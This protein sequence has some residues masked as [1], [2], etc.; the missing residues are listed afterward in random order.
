MM[1]KIYFYANSNSNRF[2]SE[3]IRGIQV[4][5]IIKKYMECECSTNL[6]SIHNSIIIFIKNNRKLNIETLKNSKNNNNIN[7]ID[8]IDYTEEKN[9]DIID[10]NENQFI[11]YIDGL[12]VNNIFM[13]NE[14]D[15][16][17]VN[18]ITYVIPHHYDIRMN[19]FNFAKDNEIKILFNGETNNNLN[20]LHI[21]KLSIRNDFLINDSN[22]SLMN[23]LN[24][25]S[26]KKC[27][28]HINIRDENS[29]A[30]KYKPCMKLAHAVAS[31]SIIITT[32]DM[33]IRDILSIDYPY[34]LK[35]HDY[36]NVIDMIEYVKNTYNTDIWH[37]AL[38]IINDLKIKLN[39]E[40]V[41][42]NYYCDFINKLKIK[43]YSM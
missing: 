36:K 37:K 20:C 8:V 43:Y 2:G 25:D 26:F 12:I 30:Y 39:I 29:F 19:D 5:K 31:N 22:L 35:N 17:Y 15:K 9:Y 1:V 38:K 7:I 18:V 28:C 40:Y 14:F 3:T 33:S 24:N 34:I 13:K 42:E 4:C 32:Y 10:F 41:V 23:F 21:D 16:K 27:L 11:K 6:D